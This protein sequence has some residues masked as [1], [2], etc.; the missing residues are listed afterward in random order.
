MYIN[1]CDI[2]RMVRGDTFSKELFI[3]EGTL[4]SPVQHVLQENET[5]Y[6]GIERPNEIFENAV[7]KK[8]YTSQDLN[9]EGNVVF[10]LKPEETVYLIPGLYYYEIKLVKVTTNLTT[11][12]TVRRREYFW[13]EE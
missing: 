10:Y 11:V 4:L 3:N 7:I 6:I 1:N 5:L 9:T 8:K 12:E 13:I 2:L